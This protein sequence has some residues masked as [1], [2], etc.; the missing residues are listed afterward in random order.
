[1]IKLGVLPFVHNSGGQVEIVEID[2]LRYNDVDDA[3]KK[4]IHVLKNP[5]LEKDLRVKMSQRAE[6][7]SE[8]NFVSEVRKIVNDF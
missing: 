6:T 2:E 3:V 5:E 7:F 8:V 1:M 4:I